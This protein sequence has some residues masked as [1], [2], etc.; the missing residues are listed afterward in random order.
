MPVNA[1]MLSKAGASNEFRRELAALPLRLELW[2][3]AGEGASPSSSWTSVAPRSLGDCSGEF[4]SES[5]PTGASSALDVA[6]DAWNSSPV[7]SCCAGSGLSETI[8]C[9]VSTEFGSFQ[10]NGCLIR[11]LIY[12]VS[13]A[14]PE[15]G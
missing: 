3:C 1:P 13:F 12:S 9:G 4:C 7:S 6:G 8:S 15:S 2:L 11:E 14:G 5:S 10:K